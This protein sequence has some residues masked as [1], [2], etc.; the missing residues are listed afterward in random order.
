MMRRDGNERAAYHEERETCLDGDGKKRE[1]REGLYL[2]LSE[3]TSGRDGSRE[4]GKRQQG[5]RA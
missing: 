1:G 4:M 5:T 3:P 2:K